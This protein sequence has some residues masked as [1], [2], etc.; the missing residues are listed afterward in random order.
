MFIITSSEIPSVYELSR[1]KWV[2]NPLLIIK[3]IYERES[4]YNW[5]YLGQ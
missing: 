3:D 5:L 2:V 4:I 1:S